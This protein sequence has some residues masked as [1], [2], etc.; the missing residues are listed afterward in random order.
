RPEFA[1]VL[2]DKEESLSWESKW[3]IAYDIT[4]ALKFLHK[5]EVVHRD[6]KTDNVLLYKKD[7][8]VHA[9]VADFGLSK[10][11]TG[12]E[13]STTMTVGTCRYMAPE[14]VLGV[15]GYGVGK[16]PMKPVDIYALGMTFVALVTGEEPYPETQNVMSIPSKVGSGELYQELDERRCP[17]LFFKLTNHCRAIKQEDRPTAGEV[18]NELS[19]MKRQVVEF[20]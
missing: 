17:F 16:F 15:V 14:M 10:M 19:G 9:K 7:D 8:V 6:L 4:V 11:Q 3:N 13:Q 1:L 18:V 12:V 5:K 2:K 20:K